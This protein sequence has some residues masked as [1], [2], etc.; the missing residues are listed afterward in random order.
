MTLD[1]EIE[2]LRTE[3]RGLSTMMRALRLG[4]PQEGTLAALA[5]RAFSRGR[6]ETRSRL[7][8]LRAQRARERR[9]GPMKQGDTYDERILPG[10]AAGQGA[11]KPA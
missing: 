3:A 1:E 2:I 10:V 4:N 5:L 11:A 9:R 8:R 6:Q 7:S